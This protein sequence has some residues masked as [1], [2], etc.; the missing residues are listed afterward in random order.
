MPKTQEESL[1]V[2]TETHEAC[3]FAYTIVRSDGETCGPARY[4]GEELSSLRVLQRILRDE[5]A[6]ARG[7]SNNS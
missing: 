3:G 2:R 7:W 6:I 4:P 5:A 1:T